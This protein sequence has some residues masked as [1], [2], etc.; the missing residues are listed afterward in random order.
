MNKR[1]LWTRAMA[2]ALAAVMILTSQTV[3]SMG[4]TL[5]LKESQ[6]QDVLS[7]EEDRGQDIVQNGSTYDEEGLAEE[8]TA[9]DSQGITESE[10]AAVSEPVSEQ[11]V[12][13][14][15]D[16]PVDLKD[17]TTSVRV[18]GDSGVL[19]ADTVMTAEAL[20]ADR[21]PEGAS[22]AIDT[23][24]AGENLTVQESAFYDINMNGAQPSGTVRVW[25]P[26]PDEWNGV[27]DAWYI[28]AE[29]HV[30]NWDAQTYNAEETRAD[31]K[32]YY[33][34]D[35]GHFSIYGVTVSQEKVL[36]VSIS[37]NRESAFPGDQVTLSST[38]SEEGAVLQ[39]QYKTKDGEWQNI[40]GENSTSYSF[41]YSEENEEYEYRLQAALGDQTVYSDSLTI[42]RRLT[43]RETAELYYGK[44]GT[45]DTAN[46][47]VRL[48]ETDTSFKAGDTVTMMI[49][50]S[51]QA[52]ALYNYG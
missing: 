34:F 6:Q 37:S 31:G 12:E 3:S 17:E 4:E 39:W 42:T 11:P 26:I 16:Q 22:D 1:N 21:L 29:G 49:S 23:S 19:P 51:L 15:A 28:D 36:T 48:E 38:V 25:V 30:Q 20:A 18:T 35:T 9:S 44:N 7:G 45:Q 5:S 27:L 47:S 40:P 10:P 8:N 46:V 2:F 24:L 13:D 50:Y 43:L 41:A 33:V 32:R 14:T 52:A